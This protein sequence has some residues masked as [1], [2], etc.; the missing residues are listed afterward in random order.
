VFF[1][2]F[3]AQNTFSQKE[4]ATND[5][6]LSILQNRFDTYNGMLPNHPL[7]MFLLRIKQNFK[8]K[9][10]DKQQISIELS[11]GNIQ[12]PSITV[13]YPTSPQVQDYMA[14]MPW[15]EREPYFMEGNYEA[16]RIVFQADGV[17]RK[18]SVNY[19][20]KLFKDNELQINTFGYLLV[21]GKYPYSLITNDNSIEFF[22]SN[23]SG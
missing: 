14:N 15:H 23:I 8:G 16:K 12:L 3:L 5:S 4:K 19:N 2:F 22:H 17:L 13:Y 6:L 9:A 18:L 21:K 20:R 11:S 10:D 1:S 7:G